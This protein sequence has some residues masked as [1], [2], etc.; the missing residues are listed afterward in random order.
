MP[1]L[2]IFNQPGE[3][4]RLYLNQVLCYLLFLIGPHQMESGSLTLSLWET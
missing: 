2:V 1:V 3:I 4:W